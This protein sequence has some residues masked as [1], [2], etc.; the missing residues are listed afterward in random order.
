M[1]RFF[2]KDAITEDQVWWGAI[3]IPFAPQDFDLLFDRVI[4]YLD[5]KICT[6]VNVLPVQNQHIKCV[7]ESKMNTLG[8]ICS[9]TIC[10]FI[11]VKINSRVSIQNVQ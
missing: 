5:E 3:I 2:I 8:P 7:C 6:F 1:D 11:Q 9:H 4:S 10:L